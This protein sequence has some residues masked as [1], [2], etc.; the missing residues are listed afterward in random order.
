MSVLG[1]LTKIYIYPVKSLP[2]IALEN[3]FLTE[4]GLAHPNNIEIVDRY[5]LCNIYTLN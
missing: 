1:K 3:A 4:N 5:L 2:G